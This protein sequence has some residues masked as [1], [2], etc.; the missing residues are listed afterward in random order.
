LD[1]LDSLDEF[2]GPP[3]KHIFVLEQISGTESKA[4]HSPHARVL[5]SVSLVDYVHGMVNLWGEKDRIFD[6]GWNCA[7]PESID[8]FLRCIRVKA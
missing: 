2:S 3:N 5:L 1:A 8:H 4:Q 7:S 6:H